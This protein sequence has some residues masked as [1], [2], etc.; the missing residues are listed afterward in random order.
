[1]DQQ[2]EFSA[3]DML[4]PQAI[5]DFRPQWEGIGKAGE[6]QFKLE[7]EAPSVA[8]VVSRLIQTSGLA[9]CGGTGS[10]SSTAEKAGPLLA[11]TFASGERVLV[12]T[13]LVKP[14]GSSAVMMR[15]AV[16]CSNPAI[17]PAVSLLI[18][19]LQD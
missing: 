14:Q 9:A 3:K 13:M 4:R 11:G 16:R 17:V 12:R 5:S 6:E 2:V 15:V 8:S 19:A 18:R 7:V 10:V 1:M